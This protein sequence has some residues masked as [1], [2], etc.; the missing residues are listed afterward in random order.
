[1]LS[2]RFDPSCTGFSSKSKSDVSRCVNGFPYL[3]S[4]ARDMVSREANSSAGVESASA[5]TDIRNLRP[6][7]EHKGKRISRKRRHFYE[8]VSGDLNAYW[9][10][11]RRIKVFWPLDETWYYGLVSEYDSESKLHHINYDDKD[12]EWINLQNEKFKLLLLP[13]EVPLSAKPKKPSSVDKFVHKGKAGLS[14]DDD[15]S[16]GT[17]LDS[18]PIISWLARSSRRVKPSPNPLKKQKTMQAHLPVVSRQWSDETDNKNNDVDSSESERSQMNSDSAL[19]D[20]SD[21]AKRVAK[22]RGGTPTSFQNRNP[23]VYMRK[24]FRNKCEGFS[25]AV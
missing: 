7:K 14:A 4:S 11:N 23:V 17:Y 18:E 25:S 16:V 9:V 3:V 20:D 22:S 6:R 10:L 24:R 1:M 15:S 19:P 5:H 8:I 13:S 12:E 2:S 21:V